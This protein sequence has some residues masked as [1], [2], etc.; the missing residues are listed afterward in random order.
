MKMADIFQSHEKG[1]ITL[2]A[3]TLGLCARE[4]A[5]KLIDLGLCIGLLLL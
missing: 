4:L 5:V 1:F 2:Q 3:G